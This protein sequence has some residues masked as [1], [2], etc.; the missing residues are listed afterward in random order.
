MPVAVADVKSPKGL[1]ESAMFPDEN[2]VALDVRLTAYIDEGESRAT[3]IADADA[4]DDA[5]KAWTYWRAFTAVFIRLSA[6]PS[7]ATLNDQASASY[8]LTQIQHFRDMAA[9]QRG[10]F[11]ALL[12]TAAEPVAAVVPLPVAAP[13]GA[14]RTV[15]GW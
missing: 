11:D 12:L 13:S 10:I 15:F 14:A 2:T 7:S 5:V 9:E 8:L 6:S 4:N 3:P 1:I